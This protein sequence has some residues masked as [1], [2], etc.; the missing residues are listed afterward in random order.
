MR[1]ESPW[2][3]SNLS[4]S[5]RKGSK[6]SPY[7]KVAPE[8][9]VTRSGGHTLSASVRDNRGIHEIESTH[10]DIPE[11]KTHRENR[12]KLG[13][14][15]ALKMATKVTRHTRSMEFVKTPLPIPSDENM[16]SS[17]DA[18]EKHITSCT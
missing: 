16:V 13:V 14:A 15:F 10:P 1:E 6:G 18:V 7:T 17:V 2:S 3:T 5:S 9:C 4:Y 12:L 8:P 11:G